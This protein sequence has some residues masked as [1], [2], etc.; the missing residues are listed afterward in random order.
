MKPRTV[1]DKSKEEVAP[2]SSIFGG[3][4]PVDTASKE[5]E[6][7]DKLLKD[8]RDREH[9]TKQNGTTE[10]E[11]SPSRSRES[12]HGK[13]KK[14]QNTEKG[15]LKEAHEKKDLDD[16]VADKPKVPKHYEEPKAPVYIY[17]FTLYVVLYP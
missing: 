4:K 13:D 12:Q 16:E 7:E 10:A 6:I 3:A 11:S 1:P 2:S 8:Q 5:K 14:E 9:D 17:R 15:S